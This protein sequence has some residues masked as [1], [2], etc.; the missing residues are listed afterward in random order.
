MGRAKLN[1]S[2]W[3]QKAGTANARM[4]IC[5]AVTDGDMPLHGY[6]LLHPMRSSIVLAGRHSSR[7]LSVSSP[8]ERRNDG[9]IELCQ[10][11]SGCMD[12][13]MALQEARRLVS[14]I[15]AR[16]SRRG[17]WSFEANWRGKID[18]DHP[19]LKSVR[20]NVVPSQSASLGVKEYRHPS[21]QA[22]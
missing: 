21:A 16:L 15:E 22:V 17:S 19:Q 3:Q 14:E 11:E 20:L 5:D 4:E 10:S 7:R 1:F 8:A 9:R 12:S 2:Q 18:S 6:T 13:E